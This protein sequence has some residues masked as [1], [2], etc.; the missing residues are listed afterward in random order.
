M[1][2][3]SSPPRRRSKTEAEPAINKLV[4]ISIVGQ[5]YDSLTGALAEIRLLRCSV[6]PNAR[7]ASETMFGGYTQGGFTLLEL[8]DVRGRCCRRIRVSR[9]AS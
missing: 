5:A 7:S 8:L 1:P 4:L 3:T 9:P 6:I 2:T